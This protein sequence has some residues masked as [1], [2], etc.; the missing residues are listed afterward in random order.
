MVTSDFSISCFI[1]INK[2][3]VMFIVFFI[4]DGVI[5]RVVVIISHALYSSDL[6]YI[7]N[8]YYMRSHRRSII[9]NK[10]INIF[11]IILYILMYNIY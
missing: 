7:V 11:I 4:K 5:G 8:I 2:F 6:F 3:Y 9:M 1:N 10:Y